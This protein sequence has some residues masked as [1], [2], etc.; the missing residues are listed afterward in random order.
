MAVS[1]QEAVWIGDS[2]LHD[3]LKSCHLFVVDTGKR[4]VIP[5]SMKLVAGRTGQEYNQRKNRR[6]AYWEDRYQET[7]VESGEHLAPLSCLYRHEYGTHRC[8]PPP[9][10]V[11]FQRL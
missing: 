5:K 9:V 10:K 8:D 11:V 4:D 3:Y 1:G 7:A 2:E 6:R